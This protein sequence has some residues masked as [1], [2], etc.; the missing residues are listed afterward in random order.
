MNKQFAASVLA[1]VCVALAA[2]P[3]AAG[4][5]PI[6]FGGWLDASLGG[7]YFNVADLNHYTKPAGIE[8]Q[9]PLW[10]TAGIQASGLIFE[11]LFF[12]FGVGG[13]QDR[14]KGDHGVDMTLVSRYGELDVGWAVVNGRAGLAYPFVGLGGAQTD[15]QFTG[16]VQRLGFDA[17]SNGATASRS[18]AYA[19]VGFTYFYPVR[20]GQN[21]DG[22]LGMFLPGISVGANFEA[23]G[24]GWIQGS[25]TLRGGPTLSYNSIFLRIEIG[26]GGGTTGKS[27][28]PPP[29][30]SPPA[31][32]P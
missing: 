10:P 18:V 21:E 14:E 16:A 17:S 28:A 8:A 5:E 32:A 6:A 2:A 13:S 15:L 24:Q 19:T 30:P 1:M 20:F 9:S 3:A 31:S 7:R 4:D 27:A 26:F 23:E 22:D 29:P 11:K 25:Q 12:S